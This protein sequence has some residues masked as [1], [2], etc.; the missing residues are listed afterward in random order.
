MHIKLI[1]NP[2]AGRKGGLTTN[3][4]TLDD[5][6]AALAA[7]GISPDIEET[8]EPGHATELARAAALAGYD[9]VIAAGGDGTAREAA[10]G[11]LGSGVPLGVMPLGS[12]MN[13]ARML[14]IPRDLQGAAA[15][16]AGGAVVTLDVGRAGQTYFLEAAG[17]G[18]DAALFHYTNQLDQGR[19][20]ALA[21]AARVAVGYRPRRVVVQLDWWTVEMDALMVTVAN[22]PYCGASFSVAPGAV[23]DDHQFDVRVYGPMSKWSLLRRLLHA[24]PTDSTDPTSLATTAPPLDPPSPV[25]DTH[26]SAGR[27]YSFKARDVRISAP[28]PLPGHADSLPI[29]VTP[30][31]F[32]LMPGA[33]SV[34]VP[35]ESRARHAALSHPPAHQYVEASVS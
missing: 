34:F 35:A 29:G 13:V 12:F 21:H 24:H 31:R 28:H 11:L 3:G 14:G 20:A 10:I 4:A 5:V 30:L 33:L 1:V 26:T 8:R 27:V 19:W 7:Y 25:G 2:Q 18:V 23:A 6:R 32:S 9:G 22:G 15:V 17:A 16:I